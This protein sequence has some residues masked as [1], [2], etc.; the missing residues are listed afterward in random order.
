M[1]AE[2]AKQA[3]GLLAISSH[4]GLCALSTVTLWAML[5]TRSPKCFKPK[6]SRLLFPA[7]IPVTFFSPMIFLTPIISVSV[8]GPTQTIILALERGPVLEEE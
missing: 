5:L 7:P 6:S 4:P 3:E 8:G 2:Q 1:L